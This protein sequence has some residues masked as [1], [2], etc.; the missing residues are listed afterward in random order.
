MIL[1]YHKNKFLF[2][3]NNSSLNQK[4][5]D[6]QAL[7]VRYKGK[8]NLSNLFQHQSQIKN[9]LVIPIK[10]ILLYRRLKIVASLPKFRLEIGLVSNI[11]KK[12]TNISREE[13]IQTQT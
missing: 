5:H 4:V 8:E 6:T 1:F 12:I 3:P 2:Y 11:K 10:H 13:T 7:I 9:Y